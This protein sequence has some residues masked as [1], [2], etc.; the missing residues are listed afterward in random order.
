MNQM[1]INATK[2]GLELLIKDQAELENE[3]ELIEAAMLGFEIITIK[4]WIA[5]N[6]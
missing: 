3:G 1:V 5:E 2:R 4:N 6:E